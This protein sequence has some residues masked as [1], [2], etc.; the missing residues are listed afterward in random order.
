MARKKPNDPNNRVDTQH[1]DYD[2]LKAKRQV[3]QDVIAGVDALVNDSDVYL[4]QYEGETE[5]S[6]DLRTSTATVNN[7]TKKAVKVM[8]GLIFEK[9]IDIS[10]V[11]ADIQTIC[12]NIDKQ[13]NHLNIF[14]RKSFE[15]AWEGYAA[16]LIDTPSTVVGNKA[17]QSRL[18]VNPFARL[19]CADSIW[20]WQHRINPASK[21]KELS[22]IVFQEVTLAKAGR[23]GVVEEVR[24]R[25]YEL[26][27]DD[28]V[29]LEVWLMPDNESEPVR[30]SGPTVINTTQI[31]VAVIG[32]LGAEPPLY[33]IAKKNIEHFQTWSLMTSD[34]RKTCVP[35]RVLEGGTADSIAPIGGDVTL[36]PPQGCSAYFIEVAGTSLEFVRS[37]CQDIAN[38]IALMTNSIIA[39]KAK[40]VQ[41]TATEDVIDN[42]Q[43]TAELRPMSE[44][45]KD[46]LEVMLGLIA[47]LMNM[48]KD[49]GGEIILG[50]QWAVAEQQALEAQDRRVRADEAMIAATAAKAEMVN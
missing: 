10:G 49:A 3:Y 48:G 8:T 14:A 20:N 24:Y 39:G 31:P 37:L 28:V 38:D 42:T 26:G 23:F 19:Y 34:A 47:E 32:E 22:L 18:D 44:Q 36:F 15:A 35:Q 41:K 21:A 50:T 40:T 33:D 6:Y 5:L 16:I 17:Q 27:S 43:E 45:F 4:P 29:T 2:F 1:P 25:V 13:G 46:A 11:P 30:E 7:Y 12:E 9:E